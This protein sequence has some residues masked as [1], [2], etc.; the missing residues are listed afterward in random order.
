M[1][2]SFAAN[3]CFLCRATGGM[4]PLGKKD[5]SHADLVQTSE[6]HHTLLYRTSL[7]LLVEHQQYVFLWNTFSLA[8]CLL[9]VH[10]ILSSWFVQLRGGHWGN[11]GLFKHIFST[12]LFPHVYMFIAEQDLAYKRETNGQQYRVIELGC[13][14]AT[15]NFVK[16]GQVRR[17]GFFLVLKTC[18][19]PL[20][21]V[22]VW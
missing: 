14:S 5:L 16:N 4:R 18:H 1:Y 13:K 12:D 3:L 11:L 9:L 2:T 7:V 8:L 6:V 20:P 21:Q 15:L 17:L 10:E 19:Q 22:N